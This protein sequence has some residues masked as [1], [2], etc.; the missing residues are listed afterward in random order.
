VWGLDGL[1]ETASRHEGN[2]Q[3]VTTPVLTKPMMF[4]SKEVR[5]IE[6]ALEA[7]QRQ[8]DHHSFNRKRP[9]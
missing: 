4:D 3:A 9:A 1:A 5:W 6:A 8:G 7:V 2:G